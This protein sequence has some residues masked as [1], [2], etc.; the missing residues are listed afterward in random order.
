MISNKESEQWQKGKTSKNSKRGADCFVDVVLDVGDSIV[1]RT[2]NT[3]KLS[4]L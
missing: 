1:I 2:K 4:R 3:V